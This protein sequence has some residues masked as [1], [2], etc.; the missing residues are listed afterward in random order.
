MTKTG[1]MGIINYSL[2]FGVSEVANLFDVK[3]DTILTWTY[4]FSEYLQPK[5]KPNK[6]NVRKFSLEDILVFS[7]VLMYWEDDPDIESIKYGLNANEHYESPYLDTVT[8]ITPLFTESPDN[9]EEVNS[10]VLVMGLSETGDRFSLAESYKLAGDRLIDAALINDEKLSLFYPIIYN[11]RHATELYLKSFVSNSK[12]KRGSHSLLPLLTKFGDLIL[13]EFNTKLPPWFENIVTVFDDFDP[14]GT[15][16]RYG[17]RI[18]YDE[19]FVNL[20]HVKILMNWLSDSFRT[21]ALK[22]GMQI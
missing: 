9:I 1:G 21:I 10:G 17:G 22:K 11:Y 5:A 18:K 7:Y 6:G 13:K 16:F 20:R 2:N 15:T 3:R 19:M 8:S 12:K 4:T 14:G